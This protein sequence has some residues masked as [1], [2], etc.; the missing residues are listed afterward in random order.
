[1][2]PNEQLL[3]IGFIYFLVAGLA[4]LIILQKSK[5]QVSET[6]FVTEQLLIY[7]VISVCFYFHNYLLSLF[8]GGI[9]SR[10]LWELGCLFNGK[11]PGWL[12][13]AACLISVIFLFEYADQLPLIITILFLILSSIFATSHIR[14]GFTSLVC[15]SLRKPYVNSIGL[16]DDAS[17]FIFVF[18]VYL[19]GMF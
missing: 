6:K 5:N 1:M 7:I 10:S 14:A 19:S 11:K 13:T 12:Q 9:L 2:G 3:L 4:Y 8:V 17:I 16:F 18:N 15:S